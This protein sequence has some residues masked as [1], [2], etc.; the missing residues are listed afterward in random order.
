[1]AELECTL[2]VVINNGIDVYE[3]HEDEDNDTQQFS[4]IFKIIF[5]H[6]Y[7]GNGRYEIAVK[8]PFNG[9]YRIGMLIGSGWT[10]MSAFIVYN[11][12][13][14][15]SSMKIS[16]SNGHEMNIKVW[17]ISRPYAEKAVLYFNSADIVKAIVS[18]ATE[19]SETYSSVEIYHEIEKYKEAKKWLDSAPYGSMKGDEPPTPKEYMNAAEEYIR[20][21]REFVE[22]HNNVIKLL[23]SSDDQRLKDLIEKLK[24]QL[25]SLML[26]KSLPL[27]K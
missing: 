4:G 5:D 19:I 13:S 12:R 14:I 20:H 22:V 17:E 9:Y 18:K 16:D 21:L 1:M 27:Y 26:K 24:S 23:E 15:S 25:N 8:Q 3:I 11:W 2:G 10:I 7:H 6:S